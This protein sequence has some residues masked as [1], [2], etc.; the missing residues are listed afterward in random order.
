MSRLVSRNFKVSSC[1]GL[2]AMMSRFGLEV[3]M[4]RL[5]LGRFGPRSSSGLEKR[6]RCLMVRV[7]RKLK[8]T[9]LCCRARSEV[10]KWRCCEKLDAVE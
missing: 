7:W 2:E 9:Y 1:L 5:G 10:R 3:M 4:Y 6:S 8:I